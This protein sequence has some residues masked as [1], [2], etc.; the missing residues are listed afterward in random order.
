MP[1]SIN[2][3]GPRGV[4]PGRTTTARG[5]SER[6]RKLGAG[7]FFRRADHGSLFNSSYRNYYRKYDPRF[8]LYHTRMSHR[9]TLLSY[10]RIY[11]HA[12]L[13]TAFY[14]TLIQLLISERL[15]L[16]VQHLLVQASESIIGGL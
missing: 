3:T 12:H 4:A 9:C 2:D 11:C 6:R 8:V 16:R 13:P 14:S 7:H 10:C 5:C 1:N 15:W